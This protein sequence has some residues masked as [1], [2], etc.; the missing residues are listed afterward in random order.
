MTRAWWQRPRWWRAAGTSAA[1]ILGWVAALDA[2]DWLDDHHPTLR[3]V[4]YWALLG[5]L[6]IWNLVQRAKEEKEPEVDRAKEKA[7]RRA[8]K[9]GYIPL[10]TDLDVLRSELTRRVERQD[11]GYVAGA[12]VA[13]PAVILFHA[14]PDD[15][16]A[17]SLALVLG[18]AVGA[19]LFI[20][21]LLVPLARDRRH[22]ELLL[23]AVAE[24]EAEQGRHGGAG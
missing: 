14:W 24:R 18:A 22:A 1:I 7:Q 5:S 21:L 6:I 13:V 19:A 8:L 16:A 15:H 17:A 10:G 11:S 4:I 9:Q 12:V 23:E 3:R 20:A 2:I